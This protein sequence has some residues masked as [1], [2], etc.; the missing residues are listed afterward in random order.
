MTEFPAEVTAP[1]PGDVS[2]SLRDSAKAAI[3]T[4]VARRIQQDPELARNLGVAS[5]VERDASD[6]EV[7]GAPSGEPAGALP[8]DGEVPS[9]PTGTAEPASRFMREVFEPAIAALMDYLPTMAVENE[10]SAED[11]VT[12]IEAMPDDFLYQI[13]AAAAGQAAS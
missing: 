7:L 6:Q 5:A 11:V 13:I 4:I 1:V 12:A 10:F 8:T 9:K 3:A 2:G